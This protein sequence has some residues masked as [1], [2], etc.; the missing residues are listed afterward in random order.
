MLEKELS[1]RDREKQK[2]KEILLRVRE[3]SINLLVMVHTSFF[4]QQQHF[5]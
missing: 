1:T 2:E 5:C 3:K 4:P